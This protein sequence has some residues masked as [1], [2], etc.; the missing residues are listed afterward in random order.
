[1]G[2]EEN[3]HSRTGGA[4]NVAVEYHAAHQ[5]DRQDY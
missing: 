4:G 5:M 3:Q 2:L 1:M